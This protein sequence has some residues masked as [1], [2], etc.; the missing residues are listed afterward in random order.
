MIG[1]IINNDIISC[2]SCSRLGWHLEHHH[3]KVLDFLFPL[4]LPFAPSVYHLLF[5]I[6]WFTSL[7]LSS[8]PSFIF[9]KLSLFIYCPPRLM[10]PLPHSA[11]IHL[12]PSAP[13][14]SH[15]LFYTILLSALPT[16]LSATTLAHSIVFVCF[17]CVRACVCLWVAALY[18]WPGISLAPSSENPGELTC[19]C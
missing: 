6:S 4:L 14:P 15:S 8:H 5:L 3:H 19:S 12:P 10:H 9:C 2:I 7:S 1:P 17:V 11:F 18:F 13:S 16:C